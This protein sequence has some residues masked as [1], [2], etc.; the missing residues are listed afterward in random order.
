MPHPLLPLALLVAACFRDG[1]SQPPPG[2]TGQCVDCDG[3]MSAPPSNLVWDET[4]V[5]LQPIDLL[6]VIEAGAPHAAARDALA[7]EFPWTLE[8][9]GLRIGVVAADGEVPAQFWTDAFDQGWWQGAVGGLV[10][11]SPAAA[12]DAAEAALASSTFHRPGARLVIAFSQ[13]SPDESV[14]APPAADALAEICGTAPLGEALCDAA[15][16]DADTLALSG[17]TRT[18]YLTEV[19]RPGTAQVAVTVDGREILFDELDPASGYGDW[20]YDGA[21]NSVDFLRYTPPPGSLVQAG[22]APLDDTRAGP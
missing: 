5:P 13:D 4:R 7:A 6:W 10:A 2:T 12:F 20:T 11:T 18:F 16:V 1:A 21:A 3:S 19:P 8:T 22:Y 15:S 9:P 17:L 14:A